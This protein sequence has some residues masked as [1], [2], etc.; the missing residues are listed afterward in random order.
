MQ[1]PAPTGLFLQ[2]TGVLC[3]CDQESCP[4]EGTCIDP[5]TLTSLL[6]SI[7]SGHFTAFYAAPQRESLDRTESLKEG[8]QALTNL[9]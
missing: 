3:C 1:G 4:A 8:H 9:I 2:A 6:R 5:L 7:I